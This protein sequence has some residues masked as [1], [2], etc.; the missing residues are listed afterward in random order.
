MFVYVSREMFTVNFP[1]VVGFLSVSTDA[2][3]IIN[4][5]NQPEVIT[6]K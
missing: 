1:A 6:F 2:V 3:S 5:M 4:V